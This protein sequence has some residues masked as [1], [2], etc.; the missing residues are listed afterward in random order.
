MYDLHNHLLP[1]IDDGAPDIGTSLELA[2]IAYQEGIS[3]M[4]CTPHIHI[5]RFNN[6]KESINTALAEFKQALERSHIP[7]RVEAAAEVRVGPELIHLIKQD[8]LPFLGEWQGRKVLLLEF[9]SNAIPHGSDNLLKWLLKEGVQ[10]LIAHP[11]RNKVFQE[12]PQKLVALV[13]S[14]CLLQVTASSLLGQFGSE[15]KSL[16]EYILTERMA[17]II[18]TDAHN[19][20]Y[21]PPLI[22]EAL[23]KAVQLIGGQRATEL[24]IDNPHAMTKSL[25]S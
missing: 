14:G 5:G 23:S 9:A 20:D 3:Y 17:T 19:V 12:N 10:P 11:E 6:T 21:R 22:K 7:M 1:G 18:A 13:K 15:A 8:K 24:V 16:A 4:V 2:K 25:F